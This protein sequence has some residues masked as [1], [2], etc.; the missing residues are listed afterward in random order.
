[1]SISVLRTVILYFLLMFA[2]R[3]MGKRQIGEL[4]PSEFIVA[5]LLSDLAAVPMQEN[6]LPLLNG[7]LPILTLITLEL[8]ISGVLLKLPAVSKIISGSPVPIIKEGKIDVKAMKKLR[9]TVDDLAESLREKDIFEIESVQYAIAETNGSISAYCFAPYQ[10]ATKQ[11]LKITK[12]EAM[13]L[14]V[15]SDGTV[16]EWA[17]NLTGH[18]TQWIDDFLS[19]RGLKVDDVF[20]MTVNRFDHTYLLTY[21]EMR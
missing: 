2:M 6:D 17:V 1:M 21:D 15:I 5:L 4:Q 12:Q 7:I 13:P 3:V 11:D 19:K 10:A 16:L 9:I 18:D 8:I 14:L 20:L